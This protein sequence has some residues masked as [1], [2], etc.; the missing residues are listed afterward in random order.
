MK[1]LAKLLGCKLAKFN[2][3]VEERV[4]EFWA[5]KAFLSWIAPLSGYVTG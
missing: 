3:A 2:I 4:S 5:G 1:M